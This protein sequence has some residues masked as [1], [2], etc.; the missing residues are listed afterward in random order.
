M[1]NKKDIKGLPTEGSETFNVSS[2]RI[3]ERSLLLSS[4]SVGGLKCAHDGVVSCERLHLEG[5]FT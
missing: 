5:G 1:V 3:E 4:S 2:F